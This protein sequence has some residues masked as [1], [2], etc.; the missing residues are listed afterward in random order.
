MFYLLNKSNKQ[1][2]TNNKNTQNKETLKGYYFIYVQ[3]TVKEQSEA[4]TSSVACP[5]GKVSGGLIVDRLGWL[6]LIQVGFQVT[7]SAVA[8]QNLNSFL[9]YTGRCDT[10]ILQ[11]RKSWVLQVCCMKLENKSTGQNF[12]LFFDEIEKANCYAVS[13]FPVSTIGSAVLKV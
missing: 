9:F 6:R 2:A 8:T 4:L 5:V 7:E 11:T 1:H 12:Y 13:V 10:K 3:N